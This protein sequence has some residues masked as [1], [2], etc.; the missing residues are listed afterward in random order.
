[1]HNITIVWL[2]EIPTL[3]SVSHYADVRDPHPTPVTYRRIVLHRYRRYVGS[4]S[5]GTGASSERYLPVSALPQRV[6]GF[7]QILILPPTSG[8]REQGKSP[9]AHKEP[10]W[11]PQLIPID[12]RLKEIWYC[13]ATGLAYIFRYSDFNTNNLK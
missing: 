4:E 2:S 12:D 3:Y 9:Y 1:M 5:S 13:M 6:N 8:Q 7:S 11:G 10:L